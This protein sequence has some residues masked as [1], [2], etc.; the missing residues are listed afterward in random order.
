MRVPFFVFQVEGSEVEWTLGFAL[1]EVDFVPHHDKM[2][3]M[4][5]NSFRFILAGKTKGLFTLG[6]SMF[7]YSALCLRSFSWMMWKKIRL[8]WKSFV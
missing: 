2:H 3:I 5:S 1:A 8:F 6:S 4:A 7:H